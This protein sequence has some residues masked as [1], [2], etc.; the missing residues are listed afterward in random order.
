MGVVAPAAGCFA[1]PHPHQVDLVP[2]GWIGQEMA[3]MRPLTGPVGQPDRQHHVC[4]RQAGEH[5]RQHSA[6]IGPPARTRPHRGPKAGRLGQHRC[7]RALAGSLGGG[8]H[9]ARQLPMPVPQVPVQG[10]HQPPGFP[11]RGGLGVRA[12]PAGNPG[13][14]PPRADPRRPMSA[15]RSVGEQVPIHA[16]PYL[17]GHMQAD[18]FGQ[19]IPHPPTGLDMRLGARLDPVAR[20][21]QPPPHRLGIGAAFMVGGPIGTTT[22][23]GIPLSRTADQ[24]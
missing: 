1:V 4:G 22:R 8:A 2:H 12:R 7:A 23:R 20:Q 24:D 9:R 18:R 3:Q 10:A 16:L 19:M 15:P 6:V 11:H 13:E 14:I 5:H 21:P 17:I